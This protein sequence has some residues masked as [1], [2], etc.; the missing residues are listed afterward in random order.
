VG[1][2]GVIV[3]KIDT[4]EAATAFGDEHKVGSNAQKAWVVSKSC[5]SSSYHDA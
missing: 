1:G 5:K 2:I 3:G 4:E